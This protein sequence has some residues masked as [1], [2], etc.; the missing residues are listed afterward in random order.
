LR[1]ALVVVL[2]GEGL[3][4]W[5]TGYP[6]VTKT[7]RTGGAWQ[8]KPEA[9]R[10]LQTGEG[11]TP[12]YCQG[13]CKTPR[14]AALPFYLLPPPSFLTTFIFFFLFLSVYFSILFSISLLTSSHIFPFPI[15]L[16][17]SF[18]LFSISSLLSFI[19]FYFPLPLLLDNPA[20]GTP[21]AVVLG[22]EGGKSQVT[23]VRCTPASR[24]LSD[25]GIPNN[26]L[27]RTLDVP[28]RSWGSS[29]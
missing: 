13:F 25:R 17:F 2:S 15:S 16:L 29:I 28:S 12:P 7:R 1:R 10:R 19:L 27:S 20:D 21:S 24:S 14:V 6:R 11:L 23:H 22:A 3:T 5:G 18:P 8:W 9:Y 26:L 4:E